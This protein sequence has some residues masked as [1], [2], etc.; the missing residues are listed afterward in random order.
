[1]SEWFKDWFGEVYLEL[2][3][4]R[5]EA[6][7][8]SAVSLLREHGVA[9][10]GTKVLDLACGAGRH[11]V[12]LQAAGARVT[13]LDLSA[14]LLKAAR[15]RFKGPLVRGDMRYLP[16]RAGAFASVANLFTSF[17]YF[18]DDAEHTGVLREVARV[19]EPGGRFAL[20]YLNAPLVRA[21]L[22]TH[23]HKV[24]RGKQ[25][26][27]RR[28][29]SQDGRIVTKTIEIENEPKTFTERV[30][31]FDREELSGMMRAAGF[32]IT[33]AFGDYRGAPYAP[34]SPRLLLL[35]RRS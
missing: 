3:P 22:V 30:R 10:A 24:V 35:A 7:A 15:S 12:P 1:M 19:L 21:G 27:Q 33:E 28:R 25:V 4:H 34:D 17:G 29:L 6:E 18:A 5:D 14:V 16:F 11:S 23:D 31:L 26:T 8:A 20:D 9:Q 2:Y 32:T 13:G